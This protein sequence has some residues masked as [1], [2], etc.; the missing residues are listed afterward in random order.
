LAFFDPLSREDKWGS[1]TNSTGGSCKFNK[2]VYLSQQQFYQ[3]INRCITF[4]TKFSKFAFEVQLTITQGD[5]GGMSFRDDSDGQ[6]FYYFRICQN[7]MYGLFKYAGKDSSPLILLNSRSLAIYTGLGKQNK[8][9]VVASGS[10]MI[11]YINE[12]RVDQVQDSSY[13]LGYLGLAADPSYN[14]LT[15]VVYSNA[16][17]WKLEDIVQEPL[18]E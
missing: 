6:H 13:T 10:T 17:V 11:F 2:E 5:C 12:R 16:R 14:N 3:Y 8:V 15:D 1:Y 7:G 9:A 18:S 4:G